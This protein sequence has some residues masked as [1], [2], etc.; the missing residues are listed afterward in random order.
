MTRPDHPQRL[1]RPA[2]HGALFK[3]NAPYGLARAKEIADHDE[4]YLAMI[5]QL[6]CLKC[7]MEPC[8]EAAH[9]RLSSAAFNKYGA[10]LKKPADRWAVPLD[11]GCHR[12]DREALHRIGE[13]L[14][15]QNL[16]INPLLVCERLHKAKGDLPRM[17]AIVIQAIAERGS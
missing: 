17:R 1:T 14:F 8:G 13:Y 7:G 5:R 16:G 10:A 9:V 6:P 12:E 4:P 11:G 3:R 15:W 2:P